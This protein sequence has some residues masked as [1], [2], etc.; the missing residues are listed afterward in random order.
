VTERNGQKVVF[1]VEEGHV[2]QMPVQL[3]E[4]TG[5]GFELLQGPRDGTRLVANP[6]ADL[7]SGESIKE[8]SP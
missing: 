5:N 7:V 4:A 6:P 1:V 8:K 2:R 3:G